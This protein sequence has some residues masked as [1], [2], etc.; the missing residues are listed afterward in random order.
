MFRGQDWTPVTVT[1]KTH[2]SGPS[3]YVNV[4]K[5]PVVKNL[6]PICRTEMVQARLAQKLSQDELNF[7][8]FDF[9]FIF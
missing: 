4:K 5:D 3:G 6:D 2:T 1:K 7:K 9:S 8:L